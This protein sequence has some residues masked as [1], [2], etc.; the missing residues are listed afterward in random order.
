[1]KHK[2]HPRVKINIKKFHT[3]DPANMVMHYLMANIC[4]IGV[5]SEYLQMESGAQGQC[6]L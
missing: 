3:R 2:P 4:E 5:L 6:F 1:M